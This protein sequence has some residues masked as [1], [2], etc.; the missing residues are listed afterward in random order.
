MRSLQE[1]N[2]I[3]RI[4]KAWG[5]GS[6]EDSASVP[7][8][9]RMV[10][11]DEHFGEILRACDP[12]LRKDMYDAMSP[13]LKF[14]PRELE[15]YIIAAKDHASSQQF[16]TIDDEGNLKPYMMPT[17]GSWLA[18]EVIEIP[19]EQLFV[20]CSRCTKEAVFFGERK[21]DAISEMRHAG[22]A[23][24]EFQTEHICAEC[25]DRLAIDAQA[26]EAVS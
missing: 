22:W 17:V 13:N 25:L 10:Q 15:W 18:G 20:Q 26:K 16:P 1:S 6:L 24:D 8:L 11:D 5:L 7:A 9:A 23:F 3:D 2:A 21:A 4:L 12:K 19:E 14:R